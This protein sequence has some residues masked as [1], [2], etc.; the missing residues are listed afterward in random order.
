GG[1]TTLQATLTWD[2]DGSPLAGRVVTFTLNGTVVGTSA[3]NDSGTAALIGVSLA[4]IGAGSYPSGVGASFAGDTVYVGGSG[5]GVLTVARANA[6]VTV[7]GYTGVYDGAAHG[8]TGTATG[9]SGE[10]LSGLLD[11]GATYTTAGTSTV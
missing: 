10:S 1:T 11:L 3:T 7:N 4:G 8:L 2:G 9:V 5:T 6:T